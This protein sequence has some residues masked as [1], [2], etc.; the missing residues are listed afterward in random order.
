MIL[1]LG[2]AGDHHYK[3]AVFLVLY[4]RKRKSTLWPDRN[5]RV[6]AAIFAGSFW[7][8]LVC[9]I[10]I[11]SVSFR[12]EPF[13]SLALTTSSEHYFSIAVMHGDLHR[14]FLAYFSLNARSSP[15][16]SSIFWH[17]HRSRI[18]S[19]PSNWPTDLARHF[20]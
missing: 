4:F 13:F 6:F 5:M 14:P 2:Q 1:A 17:A 3:L 15:A 8:K 7:E 9:D 19:S 18:R 11:V 16:F 12:S 10:E 20:C